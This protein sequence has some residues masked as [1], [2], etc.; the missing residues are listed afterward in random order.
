MVWDLSREVLPKFG[1]AG[2]WPDHAGNPDVWWVFRQSGQSLVDPVLF[3]PWWVAKRAVEEGAAP[4]SE[5]DKAAAAVQA[6]VVA[7]YAD[8]SSP[9]HAVV[10]K[11]AAPSGPFWLDTPPLKDADHLADID[12]EL[13]EMATKL[14]TPL[15]RSIGI[16]EGGVPDTEYAGF[17]DV[18]V[19]RRGEYTNLGDVVPRQM[20]AIVAGSSP[21]NVTEGSGRRELATWLTEDSAA[22]LA[23]VM[24]NRVWQHHFGEGLVRTPGDFGVQGEPPTHPELLDFLA[25][26]LVESGWSLKEIH[27][28]ILASAA[29]QRSSNATNAQRVMDPENRLLAHM[30]RLRLDAESLRDSLIFVGDRLD[31]ARGGP[32]FAEMATPRRTLYLKTVRS[33]LSTYV[34]LFDGADSTSV[35]PS[36][37]EST[38]SP[39]ALFL[40]N[41]PFALASAEA[42]AAVAG[43]SASPIEE[44]YRR[45]YGRFPTG[46]ELQFAQTTLAQLGGPENENA[47][48][49]FAQVLLGSN[50]FY[51]ID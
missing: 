30:N 7:A 40:L 17:Q 44:M 47:L 1:E 28:T 29:Y 16:Q 11:L 9:L 35:V 13:A 8:E 15:E 5:K 24:V 20:P 34:A 25:N 43:P 27:R 42:L 32:A 36:R 14:I 21:R 4:E 37:N 18:R 19:H 39:Q 49:A 46:G 33:N 6:A 41:H 38:V 26:R 2:P 3:A 10:G 31:T 51:F 23:C 50:E 45:L 22:L 48:V 12:A